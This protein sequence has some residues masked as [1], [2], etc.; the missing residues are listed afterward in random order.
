MKYTTGIIAS[1]LLLG[2][3]ATFYFS[4]DLM[5]WLIH[6][7]GEEWALGSDNVVD[8]PSG[9]VLTNPGAMGL[10]IVPWWIAGTLQFTI[11][12]VLLAASARNA[13]CPPH[14]P[15]P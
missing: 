2:G 4:Q 13:S 15:S 5:V 1:L 7:V 12:I 8:T 6:L 11:A 14:D 10:W 9:K 3:V